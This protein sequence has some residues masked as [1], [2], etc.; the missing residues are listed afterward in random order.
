ME[1]ILVK[2]S[3][4][5][6][7]KNILNGKYSSWTNIEEGVPEGSILG[8]LFFLI[9]NNDNLITNPKLFA[10]DIFCCS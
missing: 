6:Y 1:N 8:P 4:K 5:Y 9:Y 3:L 10:D 2:Y 7:L